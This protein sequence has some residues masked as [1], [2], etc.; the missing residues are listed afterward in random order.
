MADPL[1]C[2]ICD[3]RTE[4]CPTPSDCRDALERATAAN[5]PE[6]QGELPL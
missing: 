6:P 5:E 1:C 2:F 4:L 3:W